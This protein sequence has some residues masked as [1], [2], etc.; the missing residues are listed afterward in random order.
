MIESKRVVRTFAVVAAAAGALAITAGPASAAPETT[1]C[2][3]SNL[4][5]SP[6][7]RQVG[8]TVDCTD[9]RYVFADITVFSGGSVSS[10]PQD[11]KWVNAGDSWQNLNTYAQTNPAIDHLCVHLVTY[12]DPTNPFDQPVVIGHQCV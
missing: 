2:T 7:T 1:G 11:T 10:N 5:T 6:S 4:I 3:A 12:V 8:W 9:R